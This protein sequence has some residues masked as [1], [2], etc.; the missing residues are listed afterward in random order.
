VDDDETAFCLVKLDLRTEPTVCDSPKFSQYFKVFKHRTP[1][2]WCRWN[3]DFAMVCK[4][5]NLT[6]GAN[7]IGMMVQHLLG[8]LA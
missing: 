8:G 1:E 6:D 5:L 4:G 7:Q 3:K 2:Q